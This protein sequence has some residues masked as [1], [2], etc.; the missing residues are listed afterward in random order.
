VVHDVLA[1]E[2]WLDIL[3]AV[4]PA[5]QNGLLVRLAWPDIDDGDDDIEL[6][7]LPLDGIHPAE[8]LAGFDAPDE[9]WA[10]GLITRGWAS[11]MGAVRPSQHP[12]RRRV[13]TTVLVDRSGRTVGRTTG[14]DGT[15][16]LDGPPTEGELLRLLR[17]A[18]EGGSIP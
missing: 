7:L 10:L 13:T 17:Q 5:D 9:W 1:L 4:L 15:V 12:A 14:D 8:L 11:P 3:E 6:G 18:L 2:P 16:W